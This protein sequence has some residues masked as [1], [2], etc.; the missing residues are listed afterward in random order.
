MTEPLPADLPLTLASFIGV[1]VAG[2][3]GALLGRAEVAANIS[4]FPARCSTGSA[5]TSMSRASPSSKLS[6]GSRRLAVAL[7]RAR[8][9]AA[10]SR[11]SARFAN[12]KDGQGASLPELHGIAF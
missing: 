10:R 12:A 1:N 6:D 9:D 7:I 5:F 4:A 8:V 11:Q 2:R 3:G